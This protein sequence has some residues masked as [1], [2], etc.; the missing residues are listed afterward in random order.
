LE[1]GERRKSKRSTTTK[2][3]RGSRKKVGGAGVSSIPAPLASKGKGYEFSTE[4]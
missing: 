3:K 4:G 1:G 2:K